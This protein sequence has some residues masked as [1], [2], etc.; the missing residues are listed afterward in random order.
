MSH[1]K[2]VGIDKSR[3]VKRVISLLLSGAGA[4]LGS[5]NNWTSS[6]VDRRKDIFVDFIIAL[7]ADELNP[8]F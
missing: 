3:D 2:C 1:I 7:R 8:G 4:L 6:S 5:L